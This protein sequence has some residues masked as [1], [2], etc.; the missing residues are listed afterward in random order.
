MTLAA[1]ALDGNYGGTELLPPLQSILTT[2][3][4]QDYK[5]QVFVLT[6]GEVCPR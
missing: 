4:L 5:R 1:A 6:D 3:P 2:P